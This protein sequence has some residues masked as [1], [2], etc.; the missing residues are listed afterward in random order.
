V[1]AVGQIYTIFIVTCRYHLN[2]QL[3]PEVGFVKDF[4][5]SG[6]SYLPGQGELF[7]P[8]LSDFLSAKVVAENKFGRRLW[9]ISHG[10]LGHIY[11]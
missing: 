5:K 8:N 9:S 6:F 7:S 11:Y 2:V 1:D 3:Q 10:S 4:C